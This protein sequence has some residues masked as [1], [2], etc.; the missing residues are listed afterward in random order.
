M[1]FSGLN[2]FDAAVITVVLM[3]SLLAFF[4]GFL[5]A[6]VSFIVWLG[7]VCSAVYISPY[8][9]EYFKDSIENQ[10]ILLVS[11]Y[12]AVFLVSLIIFAII[13]ARILDLVHSYR[14]GLV[15]RSL[16]LAFGFIRGVIIVCAVF[17]SIDVT[18][19]IIKYGED[20][21]R[22]GPDFFAKAQT[23]NLLDITTKFIMSSLPSDFNIY[24]VDRINELKN[25][26]MA[27][28]G[29]EN[30]KKSLPRNLDDKEIKLIQEVMSAL[31]E[32]EYEALKNKHGGYSGIFSE[33]DKM[34][35]FR[36]VLKSYDKSLADKAI[37]QGK[38]VPE[39]NIIMLDGVLNG[40][41][42][43]KEESKQGSETGYKDTN[44]KQ[45]DRLVDSVGEEK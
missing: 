9:V 43:K 22:P 2:W 10:K 31:P 39:E 41:Q 15:D 3:S 38:I 7:A 24:V 21:D 6:L 40:T 32:S 4:R 5:K 11:C 23:Y 35:F 44:I 36:D 14:K 20:N 17:F 25:K 29:V 8:A 19:Q 12:I 28:M 27:S 45:L 13:G 42:I 37:S 16:G 26:T 1:E 18:S 33:L 30:T 34:A